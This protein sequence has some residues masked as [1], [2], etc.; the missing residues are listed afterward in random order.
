MATAREMF[1][2]GKY[3][4]RLAGGEDLLEELKRVCSDHW[5]TMG[6]IEAIGAV[7]RARL[8]YYDQEA[9]EYRF[10]EIDQRLEIVSCIGNV[11]LLGEEA[12]VHAHVVL[13]DAGGRAFGG[14]LAPG[15]VLFAGEF[16]LEAFS[17]ESLRR[18][19]DEAT[20]LPLW[21]L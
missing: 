11:S 14:H 9:R 17:G 4:G 12:L 8:G 5:V 2:S 10:N 18:E 19:P 7:E 1:P 16:F 13:A 3:M 20:G 6:R 21:K 15:T